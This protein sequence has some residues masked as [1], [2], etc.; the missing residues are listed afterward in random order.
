[1]AFLLNSQAQGV[2]GKNEQSSQ[3]P[4]RGAQCSCI[5]SRPALETLPKHLTEWCSVTN[6]FDIQFFLRKNVWKSFFSNC[7]LKQLFENN[8]HFSNNFIANFLWKNSKNL[9]GVNGPPYT[10]KDLKVVRNALQLKIPR[11]CLPVEVILVAGTRVNLPTEGPDVL[12]LPSRSKA[13]WRLSTLTAFFYCLP[14]LYSDIQQTHQHT[15]MWSKNNVTL[16]A[17]DVEQQRCAFTGVTGKS[18]KLQIENA[19]NH[20]RMHEKLKQSRCIQQ[21]YFAHVFS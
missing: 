4:W 9:H 3:T 1:M 12:R 16:N 13:V 21:T 6:K 7:Q 19:W 20:A 18:T 11:W 5:G 8:F 15:W 14:W 2:S 10:C 17:L